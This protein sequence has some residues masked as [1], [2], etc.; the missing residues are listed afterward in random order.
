MFYKNFDLIAVR[1]SKHPGDIF[2]KRRDSHSQFVCKFY[3]LP[4]GEENN[5][6]VRHFIELFRKEIEK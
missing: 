5:V 4:N 1:S 2:I 6:D 3:R